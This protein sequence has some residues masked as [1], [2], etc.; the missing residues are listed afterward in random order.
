MK[1]PDKIQ[2]LFRSDEFALIQAVEEYLDETGIAYMTRDIGIR[3][4]YGL[5]GL[6]GIG[7]SG[8]KEIFVRAQDY[9]EAHDFLE[10]FFG[11]D[12]GSLS[13]YKTSDKGNLSSE[14]GS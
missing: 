12:L 9:S 1:D 11:P 8:V 10:D 2:R 6:T 13:E 4:A 14:E 7:L 3:N 5:G